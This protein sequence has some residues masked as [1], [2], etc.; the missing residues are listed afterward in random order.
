[1]KQT[2]KSQGAV[3]A[4]SGEAVTLVDT[5]LD[6]VELIIT[7][8]GANTVYLKYGPG[9]EAQKGPR[10]NKEGG[11]IVITEYTGIVSVRTKEGESLVTFVEL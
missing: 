2:A 8:D 3:T 5:Y 1:M 9:A 11:G 6:R 10:L 7:N 4:K